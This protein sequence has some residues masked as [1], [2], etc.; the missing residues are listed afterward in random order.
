M[1]IE[2]PP[3]IKKPPEIDT[4]NANINRISFRFSIKVMK[5]IQGIP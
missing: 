1:F 5:N 3:I 4:G 2:R